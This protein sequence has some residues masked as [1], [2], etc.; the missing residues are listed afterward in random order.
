MLD[1]SAALAFL[2]PS[3][4]TEESEALL[5]Q[6]DAHSF[7][8]PAIFPW[9]VG[10]VLLRR[11]H[12]DPARAEDG[13]LRLMSLPVNV[14][15][16]TDPDEPKALIPVAAAHQLS[17]FDAAYLDL[18]LALDAPLASRDAALMSAAAACGASVLDLR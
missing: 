11:F 2:L 5:D 4:R 13:L 9:E 14:T 6:A 3:Q 15:V 18:A 8:A 7:A 12:R 1:A 16:L 10:Q 17:L